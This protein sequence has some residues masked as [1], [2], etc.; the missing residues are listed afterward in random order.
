MSMGS[1]DVDMCQAFKRSIEKNVR[2][3]FGVAV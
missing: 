2:E 3:A 1:R